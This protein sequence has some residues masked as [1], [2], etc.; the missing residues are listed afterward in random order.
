MMTTAVRVTMDIAARPGHGTKVSDVLLLCIS[1]LD[2]TCVAI[3][4]GYLTG[5]NFKVLDNKCNQS[6]AVLLKEP[7]S[8]LISD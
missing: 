3:I 4:L 8:N 1:C 5:Q 6:Q 7:L 2:M